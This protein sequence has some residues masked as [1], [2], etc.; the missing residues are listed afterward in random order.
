MLKHRTPT[1]A[2]PLCH[3]RI[4]ETFGFPT[5]PTIADPSVDLNTRGLNLSTRPYIASAPEQKYTRIQ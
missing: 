3:R 4:M 1:T 5:V 2:W